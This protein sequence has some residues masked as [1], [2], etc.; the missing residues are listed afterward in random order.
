[1]RYRTATSNTEQENTLSPS[2]DKTSTET[3]VEEQYESVLVDINQ[4]MRLFYNK[5]GAVVSCDFLD[6]DAESVYRDADLV[7]MK[8]EDAVEKAIDIAGE[9]G[10]I[11]ED[12]I[13]NVAVESENDEIT[14][15]LYDKLDEYVKGSNEVISI[16][17]KVGLENSAESQL[18]NLTNKKDDVLPYGIYVSESWENPTNNRAKFGYTDSIKV[19]V[20]NND[21][22]GYATSYGGKDY[23]AAR[24]IT[25]VNS[26]TFN[27]TSDGI[28]DYYKKGHIK[29]YLGG[30]DQTSFTYDG[31]VLIEQM[32]GDEVATY[33]RAEKYEPP[34]IWTSYPEGFVYYTAMYNDFDEDFNGIRYTEDH[35]SW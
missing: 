6:E 11:N 22:R 14:Q 2:D 9:K 33:K 28:I 31:N 35:W 10:Y 3:V 19:L 29:A 7:G 1:M 20:F 12:T 23:L 13:V 24:G 27:W 30:E 21:G 25:S 32:G 16:D 8:I 26:L 34:Y 17:F 5:D 4:Q 18:I 15:A